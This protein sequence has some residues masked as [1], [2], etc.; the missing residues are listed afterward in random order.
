MLG[1]TLESFKL[2]DVLGSVAIVSLYRLYTTESLCRTA[3]G[4]FR[5]SGGGQS[6]RSCLETLRNDGESA[7]NRD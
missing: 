5:L 1:K 7:K 4:E 3:L 2:V 6:S